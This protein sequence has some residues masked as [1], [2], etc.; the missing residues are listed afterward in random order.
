MV[1]SL[2][3]LVPI[4]TETVH[5][6]GSP[7]DAEIVHI[8]ESLVNIGNVHVH[9]SMKVGVWIPPKSCSLVMRPWML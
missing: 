8:H 1:P 6:H 7:V 4:N 9:K 2:I 3:S 5:T